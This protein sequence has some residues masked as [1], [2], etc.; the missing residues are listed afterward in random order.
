MRLA[1][2]GCLILL[3]IASLTFLTGCFGR[4]ALRQNYKDY[5][6]VY[7]DSVNRQL[8]LNLARLSREEPPYFIQLGTINSQFTFSGN[9]GFTPGNVHVGPHVGGDP[10]KGD[11]NTLTMAGSAGSTITE[12]PNFQFVPLNGEPFAQAITAPISQKVFLTLYDQG[13]PADELARVMI[14]SVEIPATNADQAPH[15]LVNSPSHPSYAE[16]LTFCRHLR[17]AQRDNSLVVGDVIDGE[18]TTVTEAK[19]PDLVAANQAGLSVKNGAGKTYVVSPTGAAEL[20]RVAPAK[21]IVHTN[22]AALAQQLQAQQLF[23]ERFPEADK[24]SGRRISPSEGFQT[25]PKFNTRTFIKVLEAV[26]KEAAEFESHKD[27]VRS[28]DGS[29]FSVVQAKGTPVKNIPFGLLITPHGHKEAFL[30]IVSISNLKGS[31]GE[32][33]EA[34]VDCRY[35]GTTYEIGDFQKGGIPVDVVGELMKDEEFQKAPGNAIQGYTR[36]SNRRVFRLLTYLFTEIAI[37]PKKLP[38]QQLIQVH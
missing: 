18:S 7:A 24:K 3:T 15:F 21:K 22:S 33:L 17:D 34:L 12:T 29:S 23:L 28:A 27:A 16:F 5:S 36:H 13:F 10:T 11:Q 19:I 25:P 8:L 9:I 31:A 26:S 1:K 37:D 20:K 32:S 35:K 38:V 4:I 2:T 30:P 6:E 14:Q